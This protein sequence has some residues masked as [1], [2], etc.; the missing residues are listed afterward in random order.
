[1]RASLLSL[2]CLFLM[3]S[4][5]S[6][7]QS[8]Q[9]DYVTMNFSNI[10]ISDELNLYVD[11]RGNSMDGT[12][13]ARHDDGSLHAELTF[14]NGMIVSGG[15]WA[16][17]GR[18]TT[19]YYLKDEATVQIMYHETG[20]KLMKSVFGTDLNDRLEFIAWFENGQLMTESTPEVSKMWH[21]NGQI[22]AKSPKTDGK[23]E[24]KSTSWHKNGVIAAEGTFKNDQPHGVLRSWDEDGNLIR[25]RTYDMGMPHGVHK[26]WDLYGNLI[27]E[28]MYE[29]G[30]PHGAHKK[31]DD[32]GNLIE[33][34]YFEHGSVVA[35]LQ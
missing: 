9:E 20:E 10:Y 3:T 6:E 29:N 31:W 5:A 33:E 15:F 34:R 27:E 26:I 30:K 23:M 21:E 12:V 14:E 4:C 24:G 32:S 16:A 17:D 19:T 25:E 2:F 11:Q 22:A 13:T 1:M 8:S 18:Q 28:K 35:G 7:Y